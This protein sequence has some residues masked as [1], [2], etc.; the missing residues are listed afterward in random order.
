M[1]LLPL[2]RNI[3]FKSWLWRDRTLFWD[4]V[5]KD[6][7]FEKESGWGKPLYVQFSSFNQRLLQAHTFLG[8]VVDKW[9]LDS[10]RMN[11]LKAGVQ[12]SSETVWPC[13]SGLAWLFIVWFPRTRVWAVTLVLFWLLICFSWFQS[14]P[15]VARILCVGSPCALM[16]PLSLW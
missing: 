4:N 7:R 8:L 13:V 2:S 1:A 9:L 5:I 11:L 10:D 12:I 16:R 14:S 15:G 3:P 6:E